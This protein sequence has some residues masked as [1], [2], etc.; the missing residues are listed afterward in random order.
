MKKLNI[1]LIG[2]DWFVYDI[3]DDNHE[4]IFDTFEEVSVWFKE[5]YEKE[6]K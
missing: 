5:I 3:H 1:Y 6:S 2:D 4:Y